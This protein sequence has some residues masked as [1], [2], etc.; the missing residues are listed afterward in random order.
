MFGSTAFVTSWAVGEVK[1][2]MRMEAGETQ[3]LSFMLMTS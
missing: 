2:K 3:V 1:M